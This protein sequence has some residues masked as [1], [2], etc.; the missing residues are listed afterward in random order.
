MAY[1]LKPKCSVWVGR[2]KER[3]STS[4]QG[5]L[6]VQYYLELGDF[7]QNVMAR[8]LTT[9]RRTSEG[10]QVEIVQVTK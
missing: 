4:S 8:S 2:G 1:L 6:R 5:T 9:R 7:P 10:H 3:E